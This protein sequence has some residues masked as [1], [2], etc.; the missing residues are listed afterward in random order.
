VPEATRVAEARVPPEDAD[1]A[2]AL[3]PPDVLQVHVEDAVGEP[4]DERDVV[5]ALVREVRR[6]VVEPEARVAPDRFER[7]LRG[8]D[9]ER[10][11]RRVHL[12][13]EVHALALE[14]VEDGTEALPEVCEP[15]VPEVLS[16]R[17]EGGERVAD[18]RAPEAGHE[19]QADTGGG[20][21]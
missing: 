14:R 20:R 10:D 4:A 19:P 18:A 21:S 2:V 1:R 12:Q 6:V 8:G 11:L 13:R 9:L 5:D 16:G 3:P 7:A 15:R 17:R